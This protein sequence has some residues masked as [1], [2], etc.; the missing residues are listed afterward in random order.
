MQPARAAQRQQGE[1]TRVVA[2]ADRDE[3][4]TFRDLGVDD[5]VDA[6]RRGIDAETERPGDRA[7]DGLAGALGVEREA[8]AS[9]THGVQIAEHDRGVGHRRLAPTEPV[10]GRAWFGA[11]GMGT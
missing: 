2:S 4:N 11:C 9:K 6:E 5:A 8:A 1:E 10:A 3:A 7:L